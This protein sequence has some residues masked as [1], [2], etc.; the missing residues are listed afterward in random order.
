MRYNIFICFRASALDRGF[1]SLFSLNVGSFTLVYGSL[2]IFLYGKNYLYSSPY[3]FKRLIYKNLEIVEGKTKLK[4][5]NL[6]IKNFYR[7]K[8][9]FEKEP[10]TINW[11]NNFKKDSILSDLYN[12]S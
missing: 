4:F 1:P 8:T 9:I 5:V 2:K 3:Y 6:G 11:I 12:L 10:G 7:V